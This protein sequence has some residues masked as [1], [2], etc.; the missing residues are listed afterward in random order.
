VKED[1]IT[2]NTDLAALNQYEAEETQETHHTRA[3]THRD[4]SQL[5]EPKEIH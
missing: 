5:I 3:K 1:D 2:Q 4:V